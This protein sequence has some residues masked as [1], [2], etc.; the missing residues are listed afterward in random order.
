ME[1]LMKVLVTV[2]SK[3]GA[4]REIGEAIA[5]VLKDRGHDVDCR[6]PEAVTELAGLD[7][8]VLG[9]AVYAGR[10][11]RPARDLVEKLGSQ[12]RQ[13][14]VWLFSSGPLG[15]PPEPVVDPV[16]LSPIRETTGA[17]DHRL[18]AGKLDPKVLSFGEKAIVGALH[19]PA[20]DFRD[21]SEIATWADSIADSLAEAPVD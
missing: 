16:D 17:R 19:A 7:V 10:W 2:A 3:H 18:F 5:K 9:S 4:T 20:G 11:R 6:P 12:W 8:V 13:R 21:W 15:D 1:N 14:E